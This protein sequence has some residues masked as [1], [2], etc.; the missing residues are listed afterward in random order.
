MSTYTLYSQIKPLIHALAS[1]HESITP[2]LVERVARPALNASYQSCQY[3]LRTAVARGLLIHTGHGSYALAPHHKHARI[4]APTPAPTPAP[5]PAPAPVLTLLD[6]VS[7]ADRA[8]LRAQIKTLV[9]DA[10]AEA[11]KDIIEAI[12]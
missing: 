10:V 5:A 11:L 8:E 6:N 4:P 2:S 12:G 3:H 9:A 7:E 1:T